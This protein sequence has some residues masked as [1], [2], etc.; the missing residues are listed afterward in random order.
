MELME[1]A[2]SLR[3]A[4]AFDGLR[5]EE[6]LVMYKDM[7]VDVQN[8]KGEVDRVVAL[9]KRLVEEIKSGKLICYLYSFFW[10]YM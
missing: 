5:L 3:R 6:Q 1:A 2:L 10:C 4:T 9:G 7:E 8:Y